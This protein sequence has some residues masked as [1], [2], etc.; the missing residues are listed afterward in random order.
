[1]KKNILIAIVIFYSISLLAQFTEPKKELFHEVKSIGGK[2]VKKSTIRNAKKLDDIL[3]SYPNSWITNYQSVEIIVTNN[4]KTV[5]TLGKNSV[6]SKEQKSILVSADLYSDIVINVHY[7]HKDNI[8]KTEEKNIMHVL[9]TVY[10]EMVAECID[11][12]ESLMRY[13]KE[14][15]SGKITSKL[16]A[17]KKEANLEFC[18]NE[19]GVIE[20]VIIKKSSEDK[21]IDSLLVELI[22]KMPKWKPAQ[23]IDGSKTKQIFEFIISGDPNRGC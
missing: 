11:G 14:N 2:S 15:S 19:N 13:I 20:N 22:Y 21:Y 7:T 1:M 16:L 3:E 18:V 9:M 6:L 10:P 23:T 8:T 4:G 12:K 5:K 17:S